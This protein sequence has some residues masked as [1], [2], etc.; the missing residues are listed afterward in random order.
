MP[1]L[2]PKSPGKTQLLGVH[3]E[4]TKLKVELYDIAAIVVPGL[5]CLA[6][7]WTA[8]FG[9]QSLLRF[10][11]DLKGTELTPCCAVQLRTR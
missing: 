1:G 8:L 6:E 10:V 9:A 4:L 7:V 11:H 5:F 3:M 2:L